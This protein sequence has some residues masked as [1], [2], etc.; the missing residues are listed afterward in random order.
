MRGTPPTSTSA[1]SGCPSRSQRASRTLL[2]MNVSQGRGARR[3]AL[4]F[5]LFLVSLLGHSAAAGSMP[6]LPGLLGALAVSTAL[7]FAV[8][9]RR[10]SMLWLFGYLLAGQLLL[11]TVMSAMGHHAFALVPDTSMLLAH[12][13][14]AAVAAAVFAKSEAMALAWWRAAHRYLGTPRLALPALSATSIVPTW[15]EPVVAD[16][17]TCFS[18]ASWRGPPAL[19]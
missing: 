9:D 12:V 8:A 11:H 5:T 14:A 19:V 16:N 15:Q 10:R 1:S 3:V 17:A 7:A 2:S 6:A 18:V 13:L 4:A